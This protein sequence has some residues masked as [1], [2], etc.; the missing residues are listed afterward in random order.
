MPGTMLVS[1][2]LAAAAAVAA[3]LVLAAGMPARAALTAGV[4]APPPGE[5][6]LLLAQ[7]PA[8]PA[9]NVEANIAQLHQRLQIAPA[10]EPSFEA[11]ANVMRQNA[12]M[13]SSPPPAAAN[14]VEG[15]RLA[16]QYGQ[17]EIDGMRR[18]L[19]ALQALYASLSPA[20]QQTADAIFRQGPG[21]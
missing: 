14:A 16:I 3:G 2:R 18:L 7:A 17:Q 9:P 5:R 15:L 11:L 20:Q 8:Q 19:P 21:G 4:A 13:M 12:R 1:G 10:Q 6:P